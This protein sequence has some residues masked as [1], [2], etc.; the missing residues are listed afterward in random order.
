MEKKETAIIIRRVPVD[1]YRAFKAIC[2]VE[3]ITIQGKLVEL[4][5]QANAEIVVI[6]SGKK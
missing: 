1:T 3:G 5:R 2:A 6:K 4:M